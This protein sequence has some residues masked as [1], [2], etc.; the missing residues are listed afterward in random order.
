MHPKFKRVTAVTFGANERHDTGWRFAARD[1][2]GGARRYYLTSSCRKD[3]ILRYYA[4]TIG[5]RAVVCANVRLCTNRC[6]V[7]CSPPYSSSR[8]RHIQRGHTAPITIQRLL[9]LRA[10]ISRLTS[11]VRAKRI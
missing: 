11:E 4:A 9:H 6:W 1:D 7:S 3:R 8:I 10:R 5:R 2:G